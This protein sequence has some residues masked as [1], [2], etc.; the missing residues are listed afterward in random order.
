M[1]DLFSSLGGQNI[2][3][4][5]P[6]ELS[7][8]TQMFIDILNSSPIGI[9]ISDFETG[10]IHYANDT[11]EELH[12]ASLVG[13]SAIDFWAYPEQRYSL[14]EKFSE[15]GEVVD[16]E[17]LLK[18]DDGEEFWSLLT[19]KLIL[20]KGKE[21]LLFWVHDIDSR[22]K[23]EQQLIESQNILIE[24]AHAAGKAEVATSVLHNVGNLLNTLIFSYE[25]MNDI[26]EGST[27]QKLIDASNLLREHEDNLMDFVVN[28]P[29]GETLLKYFIA[30]S[31]ECGNERDSMDYHLGRMLD[32]ITAIRDVIRS[33]Q[34]FATAPVENQEIDPRTVVSDTIEMIGGS[35]QQYSIQVIQDYHS[36]K[37]FVAQKSKVQHILVNLLK[38]AKEELM[39][40][41]FGDRVIVITVGGD[42]QHLSISVSNNG[43]KIREDLLGKI[44][45]HGFTTKDNG[46]GFGLHSCANYMT[47]MGGSISVKN[48]ESRGVCFTMEFQ[49]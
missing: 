21:S 25:S 19:W 29:K 46:H 27:A 14:W 17:M 48:N 3:A 22:K 28:N 16:Y 5:S 24:N 33:Q 31:D 6:P 32:K 9:G 49:V 1:K 43:R 15:E 37:T 30:L 42:A 47:E 26:H 40:N 10:S 44:F 18:R 38:N 11:L 4:V 39:F 7:T 12:R 34:E 13:R 45:S 36:H 20:F 35:L 23:A 8:E 41:P 2:E